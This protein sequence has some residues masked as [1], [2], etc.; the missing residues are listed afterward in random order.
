MLGWDADEFGRWRATAVRQ[1]AVADHAAAGGFHEAAVLHAEQ[2]S[3]CAL[4]GLLRGIGAVRQATGHSL[5]DLAARCEQHVGFAL[6]TNVR[7]ALGEL[8]ASY[9]STRYPDALP[10]GTPAEHYGAAASSRA[11]AAAR[12]VLEAVTQHVDAL[13]AAAGDGDEQPGGDG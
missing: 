7:E 9:Q 8:A 11:R 4:K 10:G 5:L 2:A 3:Q 1:I 12:D 6:G 13:L